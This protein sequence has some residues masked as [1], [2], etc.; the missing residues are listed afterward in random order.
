MRRAARSS[1]EEHL[2]DISTE[3]LIFHFCNA[4]LQSISANHPL[5]TRPVKDG[6]CSAVASQICQILFTDGQDQTQL[7]VEALVYLLRKVCEL[8]ASTRQDVVLWLAQPREDE[9]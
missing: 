8:S 5:L 1:D 3:H 9:V 2:E 6:L 4:I 7:E